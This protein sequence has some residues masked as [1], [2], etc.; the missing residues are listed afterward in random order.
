MP[1][2]ASP[3]NFRIPSPMRASKARPPSAPLCALASSTLPLRALARVANEVAALLRRQ[4]W[5]IGAG[6]MNALRVSR[7]VDLRRVAVV[8]NRDLV[9]VA[10]LV[11]GVDARRQRDPVLVLVLDVLDLRLG[12]HVDA[13][14]IELA[15]VVERFL[16]ER[17]TAR[18]QKERRNHP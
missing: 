11:R 8:D 5:I 1:M 2:A 13:E 18:Q 14:V 12:W 17:R 6:V 10:A 7:G 16:R 15:D 9:M 4:R 3:R